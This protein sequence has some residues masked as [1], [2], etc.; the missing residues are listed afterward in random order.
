MHIYINVRVMQSWV[1]DALYTVNVLTCKA[2]FPALD[3]ILVVLAQNLRHTQKQLHHFVPAQ[4]PD[5]LTSKH[6]LNEKNDETGGVFR[7]RLAPKLPVENCL[8]HAA[9][10]PGKP[11]TINTMHLLES[12][13]IQKVDS[14]LK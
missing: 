1:W 13:L 11:A 2:S 14:C 3:R 7:G 10:E 12:R 8:L 9:F 4:T 5:I 6:K